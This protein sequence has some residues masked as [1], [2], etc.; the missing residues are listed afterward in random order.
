MSNNSATRQKTKERNLTD[1]GNLM[2]SLERNTNRLSIQPNDQEP[3][4]SY[5]P[6][7]VDLT[8]HVR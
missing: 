2:I 5:I 3:T 8:F 4:V 7:K 1:E 6:Q